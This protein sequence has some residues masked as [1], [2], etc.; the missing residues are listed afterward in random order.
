MFSSFRRSP[1]IRKLFLEIPLANF[2]FQNPRRDNETPLVFSKCEGDTGLHGSYTEVVSVRRADLFVRD[3]TEPVGP[4]HE[5][6]LQ[7][8]EQQKM[9][10]ADA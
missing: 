3:I 10:V 7:F 2:V 9:A 4:G 1:V 5:V 6:T 8:A